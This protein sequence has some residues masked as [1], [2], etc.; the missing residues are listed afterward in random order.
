VAKFLCVCGYSLSTSGLIPNPDEW[1]CLSDTDFDG[2]DGLVNAEEIYLR[3][4]I[5]YQ[6]PVSDHLWIFWKGSAEAP[7]LYS[8]AELPNGWT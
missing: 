3:S 7:A 6:C 2:F 8:P 4:T 5:M 1:R